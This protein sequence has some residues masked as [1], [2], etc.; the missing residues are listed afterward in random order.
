[1]KLET[2]EIFEKIE[3]VK[4]TFFLKVKI[5]DRDYGKICINKIRF[6]RLK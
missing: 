3:F 2:C 4:R 6:E 1:M 5:E